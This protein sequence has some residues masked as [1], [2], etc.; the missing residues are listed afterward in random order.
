MTSNKKVIFIGSVEMSYA[1]LEHLLERKLV[2]ITLVI[3]KS[4]SNF[5][6]D[7]K[8]LEP[9]ARKFN[10]NYYAYDYLDDKDQ[11]KLFHKL[12]SLDFQY[13]FCFGWS[14]LIS[15][16]ILSLAKFSIGFHPASLPKNKGRHPIIW[17]LVLGLSE[18]SST[19]FQMTKAA[20]E[21]KIFS[22]SKI[23][24]DP[25]ET[26]T[27]LYKKVT[28]SGVTQLTD[29]SKKIQHNKLTGRKQGTSNTNYWR[30]RTPI[31]GKI[32]WRMDAFSID[33]L[34]RALQPPYPLATFSISNKTYSVNYSK[35]YKKKN[36]ENIEPGKILKRFNDSSFLVKCSDDSVIRIQ[37]SPKITLKSLEYL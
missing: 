23:K 21:G 36:L 2:D 28:E 18:T 27:T 25:K 24:I 32:D 26:A 20:D 1:F 30:K 17:A 22:Q 9:L 29:I 12:R 15:S 10:I 19:F 35:P 13:I 7:F 6:S 33:R 14:H 3:S 11:I 16:N 34:V 37:F 8:S 31:D 5:N 4:Q